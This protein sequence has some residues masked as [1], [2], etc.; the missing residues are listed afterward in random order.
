LH[1]TRI[2]ILHATDVGGV[3]FEAAQLADL[4]ALGIVPL[5]DQSF[6]EGGADKPPE[7]T[8]QVLAIKKSGARALISQAGLAIDCIVLAHQMQQVGLHLTWLGNAALAAAETRH[9]AGALL[10]G[11]YAVTDYVPA[12]SPQALAFNRYSEATLH[13][14]GDFASGYAYDGVQIL[15]KVMRKV[16][17]DPRAIRHGILA[18]RGYR[19]VMGTYNF[20][21]H[22]D[23]LRQETVVQNVHGRLHVIKVLSF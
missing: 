3:G 18:I 1:L 16:G 8:A 17:T 20:D 13:L 4:K 22:G 9:G 10:Y 14:P 2:A 15:A 11:T 6:T 19:G 12:Q 23:G 5:T 7:L 21:K